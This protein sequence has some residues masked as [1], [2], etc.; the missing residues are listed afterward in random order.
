MEV[1]GSIGF[2]ADAIKK[3]RVERSLK[4][5]SE[6]DIGRVVLCG[7]FL[8]NES[9][10]LSAYFELVDKLVCSQVS[11]LQGVQPFKGDSREVAGFV[12]FAELLPEVFVLSEIGESIGVELSSCN[13][14]FGPEGGAVGKVSDK[15]QNPFF[16]SFNGFLV[17]S[18][19]ASNL[20]QEVLEL[21]SI[22][23]EPGG[24]ISQIFG[25]GVGDGLVDGGP[26]DGCHSWWFGWW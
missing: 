25:T 19:V 14:G 11:L 7:A 13:P 3:P 18:Q 26:L 10:L 21:V 17:E 22:S 5:L 2:Q 20:E 24:F 6:L 9:G 8:D 1:C 4:L 23:V 16:I 12:G 15:E